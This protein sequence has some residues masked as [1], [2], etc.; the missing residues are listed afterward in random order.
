MKNAPFWKTTAA[1]RREMFPSLIGRSALFDPRPMT[2]SS[3]AT[4]IFWPLKTT[5][6]VGFCV[7][8]WGLRFPDGNGGGAIETG[9]AAGG[10][11]GIAAD[12][13]DAGGGGKA[14]AGAAG[15]LLGWAVGAAAVRE[16][17]RAGGAAVAARGAELRN[18]GIAGAGAGVA[19]GRGCSLV[20]RLVP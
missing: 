20:E 5:N 13:R 6:N 12:E 1:W 11:A 4:G 2:N 17:G 19:D 16:V 14:I 15:A 7:A 9:R 10:A 3:L 18:D 8:A